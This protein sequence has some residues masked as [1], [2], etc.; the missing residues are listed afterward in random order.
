MPDPFLKEKKKPNEN[1]FGRQ[2]HG[3]EQTLTETAFTNGAGDTG[4]A[5]VE[6]MS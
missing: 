1:G 5:G 3:H 4:R 6:K 2:C